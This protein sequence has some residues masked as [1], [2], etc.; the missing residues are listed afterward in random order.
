MMAAATTEARLSIDLGAIV[1]NW[2]LLCARHRGAVAGVVKA[3]A[4][5]LGAAPVARALQAAGCAHFFVAHAAEGVALRAALGEGPMIAVLNG[6]PP[7]AAPGCTPVV[8]TP[9][10]AQAW[11]GQGR[12][13][14]H[15]DTGMNRLG[16]PGLEGLPPLEIAYVMTHLACADEP[17]HPLNET[18]RARFEAVRAA[19]PGVPGSFANSSGIFLG[20]DSEL[21]RPGAALYGIAPAPGP[22]PL[23]CVLLLDAPILQIRDVPAGETVGYSATWRTARDSRIAIVAAGYA[24]GYLRA[25]SGRGMGVLAGAPVPVVGRVSMDLTAFDITG[26]PARAGDM[27]TLIGRHNPPDAV[28]AAAGTIGYEVLTSLGARYRREYA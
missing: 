6:F 7:S 3:D 12:V 18:Q 14:L 13:L 28:A 9:E 2:R 20:Y 1:A 16:V 10:M 24:D 26:L 21:A 8:N 25:L 22:N 15:V 11:S 27:I 4:Y 5:G 23:R 19:L 17:T